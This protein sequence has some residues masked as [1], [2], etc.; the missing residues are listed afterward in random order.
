MKQF[1]RC[2]GVA[3]ILIG[4]STKDETIDNIGELI[5]RVLEI[6][7]KSNAL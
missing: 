1:I 5:V 4:V 3:I 6:V 7:N 2:G